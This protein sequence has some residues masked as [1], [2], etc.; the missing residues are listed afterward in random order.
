MKAH[1]KM[2]K[3][4]VKSE[5]KKMFSKEFWVG[6]FIVVIMVSSGFAIM[7]GGFGGD[8]S[9]EMDYGGQSFLY[10]RERGTYV[11]EIDGRNI[12]F[13]HHPE[14]VENINLSDDLVS[15]IQNTLEIDFTSDPQSPL[16]EDIAFSA[17]YVKKA[18][19]SSSNVF[20]RTG[21]T[22]ENDFNATVITCADATEFVPVFVF[23]YAN[24][25]S[26][27]EVGECVLLRGQDGNDMQRFASRIL[28]AFYGI[29]E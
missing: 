26:L 14:E 18:V 29:L 17:Y 7:L 24:Y 25:T 21:F 12:E 15:K 3:R 28:Y 11:S 16:K 2:R 27:D 5:K 4:R 1:E 20:V 22:G 10:M 6:A 23:E 13:L 9:R 8:D 19:E